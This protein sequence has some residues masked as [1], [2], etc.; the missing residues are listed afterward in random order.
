MEDSGQAIAM[1]QVPSLLRLI[2]GRVLGWTFL[3]TAIVDAAMFAAPASA[4]GGGPLGI[5]FG[6]TELPVQA[7]SGPSDLSS[8]QHLLG[9]MGGVRSAIQPY[10]LSLGIIETSEILGNPTGGIRLGAIYEGVTDLNLGF[11]MRTYFGWRGVFFARAY[12]IHGR[13][14][15]AND[16][17]NLN[18]ASGLEATRTTRLF[19][20]WYEQHIGDWLRIRVGQQSA[21]QEF[22]ISSTAKLFVNGAFGWPTMPSTDM[23]SGGPG[24]PLGTPAVRFRVDANEAPTFI[25]GLFDGNPVGPGIGNPQQRDLSGTAFRVNDGAL[26]LFETRYN[27]DNSPQNGTYRL[28]AWFNSERFPSQNRATNSVSLASPLSSGMPQLLGN[29]YSVYGI[30]D[31]PLF[32]PKGSE[33]G[34]IAFIRAMGA[35]GDRNLISF[36]GDCGLIYNGPFGRLGDT[37]GLAYG[38]AQIGNAGRLLDQD[39]ATITGTNYPIRMRETVLETTYQFRPHPVVAA[40]ARFPI[41]RQSRRRHPQ[42]ESAGSADRQRSDL[43]TTHDDHVLGDATGARGSPHRPPIQRDELS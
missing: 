33:T 17:D 16:L 4:A 26:A 7:P 38:Y 19:E 30:V 41:H 35:P 34:F 1:P 5:L 31:Q 11:D 18:T 24:Y 39:T 28:G 37:I 22:I 20:L 9:D 3:A 21:G 12:Q 2:R 40:A 25:A 36:Y 32:Q 29:D 13:G 27:P 43:W 23:P 14:L 10:G 6:E 8:R 42:S 15:S